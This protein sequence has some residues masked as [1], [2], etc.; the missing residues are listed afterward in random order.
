MTDL[1]EHA[2]IVAAVGGAFALLGKWLDHVFGWKRARETFAERLR[3]ELHEEIE[4]LKSELERANKRAEEWHEKYLQEKEQT[5]SLRNEMVA[6]SN[7]NRSLIR[8]LQE[9]GTPA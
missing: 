3:N 9:E 7:E 6:L 1:K 5:G 8:R 2:L 4:K